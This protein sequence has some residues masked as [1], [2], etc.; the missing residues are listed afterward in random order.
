MRSIANVFSARKA[1]ASGDIRG[2]AS[3]CGECAWAFWANPAVLAANKANTRTGCKIVRN[4]FIRMS[5]LGDMQVRHRQPV[6]YSLGRNPVALMAQLQRIGQIAHRRFTMR[7][8][9]VVAFDDAR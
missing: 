3:G 5:F 8:E 4:L 2:V 6:I 9:R 1:A 7:L